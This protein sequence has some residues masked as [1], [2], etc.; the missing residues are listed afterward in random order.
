MLANTLNSELDPQ[1]WKPNPREVILRMAETYV[2]SSISRY[3]KLSG[4]SGSSFRNL[5]LKIWYT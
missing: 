3:E 1:P 5:E 4:K 2:L